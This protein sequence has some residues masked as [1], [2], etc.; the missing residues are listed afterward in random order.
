MTEKNKGSMFMSIEEE[1]EEP[2]RNM[3]TKGNK[4]PFSIFGFLLS[5]GLA[6]VLV[7]T[8]YFTLLVFAE[9]R[10]FIM[11]VVGI[12]LLVTILY[13]GY[14]FTVVRPWEMA[15]LVFMDK[16]KR[17]LDS[18]WKF[19]PKPFAYLV[20]FPKGPQQVD[21][22][23]NKV[24]TRPG[25][26][27]EGEA[28]DGAVTESGEEYVRS[29][30]IEVNSAVYFF[31]PKGEKLVKTLECA[32]SLLGKDIQNL[33]KDLAEKLTEKIGGIV[34]SKVISK[35]LDVTGDKTWQQCYWEKEEFQKA[36]NEKIREE[37]SPVIKKL[38]LD[39]FEVVITE[40][41]LP[42]EFKEALDNMETARVE[43]VAKIINASAEAIS[44]T[45]K[46]VA[47]RA[48]GL[49]I[50]AILTAEE[51]GK[52]PSNV[53]IPFDEFSKALRGGEKSLENSAADLVIA[54]NILNKLKSKVNIPDK[55]VADLEKAFE[56]YL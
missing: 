15:V 44:L 18:G 23:P 29:L 30:E 42:S 32:G 24:S 3:E 7:G 17:F 5:F 49:D 12:I 35:I 56:E 8:I 47:I 48:T 9:N 46:R 52:G 16:A 20:I 14:M 37:E 53:F 21:Y 33:S 51:I 25:M 6:A 31:Y 27:I 43:K 41:N 13:T 34:K 2:V 55:T 10:I 50:Q 45:I 19:P 22:P 11:G 39:S 26:A 4:K 1:T 54:K 36:V 28:E 40:V 38:F